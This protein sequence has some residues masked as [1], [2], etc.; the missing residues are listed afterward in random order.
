MLVSQIVKEDEKA[1]AL[2]IFNSAILGQYLTVIT[3]K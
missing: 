2:L 3:A 1:I